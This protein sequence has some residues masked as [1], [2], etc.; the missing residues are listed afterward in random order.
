MKENLNFNDF[1][2]II[3]LIKVTIL[4]KI[5]VILIVRIYF[6]KGGV[7]TIIDF[8]WGEDFTVDFMQSKRAI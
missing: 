7:K 2:V 6:R 1:V 8:K 5:C 3:T 4:M